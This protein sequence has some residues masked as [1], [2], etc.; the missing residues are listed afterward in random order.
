MG[1]HTQQEKKSD[2]EWP[3]WYHTL[4]NFR[5]PSAIKAG[6]QLTNTLLPYGCLWLIMIW[7]IHEGYPYWLTLML[8]FI[9][10][11]FLV[12]I[13]ILF[14]D[15]VHG[16]L[17]PM[18]RVNTFLGHALGLLV[19]TPFDD[20]RI[21]HLR[22]H[23][24][25]ADLD[26]RGFGDIWTMTRTE[27]EK[28]STAHQIAYRL[29]RN[30]LILLG[31]GAVFSF[32]LRFRLPARMSKR[33]ARAS[34]VFT[35]LFIVLLVMVAAR[36]IGL[37]TFILIQLPVIWFAGIMGIWLFYV[38]HQFEGVYWARRREWDAL[39]A[40]ME[41]SSFYKLPAILRWLTANIGHHHVHHLSPRI[42]NY[43]LKQCYDSVP[44]L[45]DKPP[46]TIRKSLSGIHLKLW[47][48]ERKQLIGFP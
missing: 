20:W 36:T 42:P 45:K 16:S 46:L 22:H 25:Y 5:R 17:F 37:R 47:D 19:F 12:R 35:N 32:L 21:S 38:Q 7:V 39:R 33:K 44:E 14:H 1:K 23:A 34:V 18:Q 28:A 30:P 10:S 29:Y 40:A 41:G 43:Q 8:S 48:E 26:A 15:C 6:W 3:S 13:F 31:M 24:S 2:Y 11:L 4:R 9:A 27:F